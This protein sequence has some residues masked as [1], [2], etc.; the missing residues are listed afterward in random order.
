MQ[1]VIADNTLVKADAPFTTTM[2]AGRGCIVHF[3]FSIS[4]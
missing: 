2:A 4:A 3:A 1:T